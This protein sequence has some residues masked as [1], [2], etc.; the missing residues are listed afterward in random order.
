[1]TVATWS[2]VILITVLSLFK[3]ESLPPVSDTPDG[4]IRYNWRVV[5]VF[6]HDPEAFTQGLI[7]R[8]GYLYESTGKKGTSTLRKVK[9][10][11]G[12][13]IR[14]REVEDDYFAEGLTEW[15]D[16]LIQLTLS[17][18]LGFVYERS[19]FKILRT[20]RISGEGW[21]LT[22]DGEML[23]MSDGTSTLRFLDPDTFQVKRQVTVSENG[24]PV[25]RLNELEMIDDK[26]F[27]NILFRDEIAVIDPV[28]GKVTG[29]I[30][31]QKLVNMVEREAPV[32][33]LNGI[34]YDALNDRIFITG[35]MWP[36]LFEIEIW[37]KK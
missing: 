13:V 17:S 9:L 23:I 2:F 7:Y 3:M 1:M 32:N 20:F 29:W 21:G 10:E 14:Q 15:Q 8:N 34:A 36:R 28:N 35:K 30:D 33:V 12:K 31:L 24:E 25:G 22:N 27:A 4:S 16:Q 11:T 19:T 5:K 18:E 26:I 37:E 6:P